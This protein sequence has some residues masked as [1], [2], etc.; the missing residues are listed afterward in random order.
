[1]GNHGEAKLVIF[2]GVVNNVCWR[3][4]IQFEDVREDL[5]GS[6]IIFGFGLVG[7]FW[8]GKAPEIGDKQEGV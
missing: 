4:E 7:R 5:E 1:M 3:A 2:F 6:P 8:Y